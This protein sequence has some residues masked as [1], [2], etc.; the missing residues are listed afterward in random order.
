MRHGAGRQ[1]CWWERWWEGVG[2][3]WLVKVQATY[4]V[5]VKI[6]FDHL[7]ATLT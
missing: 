5:C 4:K 6:H 1:G 7:T 3:S 2:A